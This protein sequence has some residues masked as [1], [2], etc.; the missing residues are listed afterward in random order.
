MRTQVRK[1]QKS[2]LGDM[3][4]HSRR[5]VSFASLS[6]AT[7]CIWGEAVRMDQNKLSRTLLCS[8]SF[9][10]WPMRTRAGIQPLSILCSRNPASE[11]LKKS[12]PSFEEVH[13]LTF[14]FLGVR[15]WCKKPGVR[16]RGT[17]VAQ[18][19]I[20][21]RMISAVAGK[22]HIG[23][24]GEFNMIDESFSCLSLELKT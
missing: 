13:P 24:G 8:C 12:S 6:G 19:G 2:L 20:R 11:L 14:F 5:A 18:F 21:V 3:R 7:H 4:L 15:P 22:Y 1:P 9:H 23:E 17:G 16:H 10:L